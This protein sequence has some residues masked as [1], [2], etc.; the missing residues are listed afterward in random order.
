MS[1]RA[2]FFT[3][4]IEM[5]YFTGEVIKSAGEKDL[6]KENT[7][8]SYIRRGMKRKEIIQLKRDIFVTREYF[9]RNKN[10]RG[11]QFFLANHL[12][13]GSYISLDTALD[14][15]GLFPEGL[16][17][18]VNSVSY[19]TTREF[20]NNVA[21]FKYKNI[22][23]ELFSDFKA[24]EIGEYTVLIAEVYKALF[25]YIYY[26]SDYL[27]NYYKEIWEDLRI[28][29]DEIDSND[30]D[31]LFIMLDKYGHINTQIKN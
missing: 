25:D 14:Y 22:K 4:F 26:K 13:E 31:K 15:Y 11:Y 30:R 2:V 16:G 8:K 10:K 20:I 6:I 19:K 28:D 5:P 12:L 17:N 21:Y 29:L 23:K 27:R 9:D 3:K 18:V 24:V 1:N 7:L